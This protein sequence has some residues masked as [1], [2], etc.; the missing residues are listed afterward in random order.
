MQT[1][2]LQVNSEPTNIGR[3]RIASAITQKCSSLAGNKYQRRF[4]LQT[5]AIALAIA[6]GIVV[7]TSVALALI[8][9]LAPMFARSQVHAIRGPASE[10]ALSILEDPRLEHKFTELICNVIWD[11]AKFRPSGCIPHAPGSRDWHAEGSSTRGTSM[12]DDPR[13][14]VN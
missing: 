14:S 8:A 2:Y 11:V 1:E 3:R 9:A 10:V 4:L 6:L 12:A 5:L 13:V 7:G